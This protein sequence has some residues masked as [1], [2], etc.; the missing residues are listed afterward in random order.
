[1][2]SKAEKEIKK[3]RRKIIK[4]LEKYRKSRLYSG[5]DIGET[6]AYT[7]EEKNVSYYVEP[8]Y[9]M[10]V[11]AYGPGGS[12]EL[13]HHEYNGYDAIKDFYGETSELDFRFAK[14]QDEIDINLNEEIEKIKLN[15]QN[16]KYTYFKGDKEVNYDITIDCNPVETI[17]NLKEFLKNNKKTI[18]SINFQKVSNPVLK[19]LLLTTC[20]KEDKFEISFEN[21][22]EKNKE[23]IKK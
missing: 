11:D 5:W 6:K 20:A 8:V 14:V 16:I 19:K 17:L 22:E 15:C 3:E 1:M 21:T 13:S 2:F 18:K 9:T 7:I 10:I 23:L 4:E 12:V